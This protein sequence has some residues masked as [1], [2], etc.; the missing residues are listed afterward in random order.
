M[1]NAI[2]ESAEGV[3]LVGGGPVPAALMRQ[4]LRLAPRLVAADGGADRALRLGH[5]PE[6]VIGDMDS[7]SD[8]ARQRLADRLHPVA[9]QETTDFDK[10]LRSI[11]APFVLGLGFAGARMD[12][13]LAVL[14]AL[15][16]HA[17]R[18]CLILSEADVAFVAPRR[19][20]L[21][22]PVGT[23]LSL[24]PLGQTTGRSE[25]LRWPIEG[26]RFAPDGMIGT[27]NEV[28]AP[29][30][31]LMFDAP[32]MLVV[33]PRSQLRR[34]LAALVPGGPAPPPPVRGG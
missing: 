12:H 7:L 13:G 9:E 32:R 21:R 6:A 30:V 10:A 22:L 20:G 4:A 11:R 2:V 31:R 28:T 24:F 23:R 1:D 5:L 17:D 27:S 25:G 3:T 19:L 8:V 29:Q 26:V 18:R 15:V 34:A 33:L 14:N 16:R